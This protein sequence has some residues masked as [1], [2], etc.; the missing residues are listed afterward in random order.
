[1]CSSDLPVRRDLLCARLLEGRGQVLVTAT[2][3]EHLPGS[4]PRV[5]VGVRDGALV[6]DVPDAA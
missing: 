3:P 5:E 4:C 1:M 6:R 2:E